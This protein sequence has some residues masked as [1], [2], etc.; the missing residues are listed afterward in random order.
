MPT[1]NVLLIFFQIDSSKEF[2]ERARIAYD[3]T[4]KRVR[5]TELIEEG[6]EKELVDVFRLHN[7]VQV[8]GF[9]RHLIEIDAV[10]LAIKD[11]CIHSTVNLNRNMER[12]TKR[13]AKRFGKK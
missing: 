10:N 6:R 1:N 9:S 13:Q 4:N 11:I 5:T 3:E 8:C 2:S 7:E 12:E